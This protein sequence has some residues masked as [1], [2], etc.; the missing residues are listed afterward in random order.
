MVELVV[1]P[2]TEMEKKV[3]FWVFLM[4]WEWKVS[5]IRIGG[6]SGLFEVVMVLAR[7]GDAMKA[8]A[9]V[10][11]KQPGERLSPM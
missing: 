5:S 4:R 8:L 9:T 1:I 11:N 6:Q 3:K 2:S 10:A 7:W